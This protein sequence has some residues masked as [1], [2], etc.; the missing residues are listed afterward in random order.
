MIYLILNSDEVFSIDLISS[1]LAIIEMFLEE[2]TD[3]IPKGL[4]SAE[5]WIK[6][7]AGRRTIVSI[8]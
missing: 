7:P 1:N 5:D 8:L 6:D 3:D 4:E 2:S